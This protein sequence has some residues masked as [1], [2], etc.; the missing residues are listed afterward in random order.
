[1][2]WWQL[3]TSLTGSGDW[4]AVYWP[5]T[6]FWWLHQNWKW[7]YQSTSF[8]KNS[9]FGKFQALIMSLTWETKCFIRKKNCFEM[10]DLCMCRG[11]S[12]WL[13]N[14]PKGILFTD[15]KFHLN[16]SSGSGVWKKISLRGDAHPHLPLDDLSEFKV[17][18][19][20]FR[21]CLLN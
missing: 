18:L 5:E 17:G 14:I 10:R 13:E 3:T 6:E 1:M 20:R 4:C 9:Y 8:V 2:K 16:S 12:F 19:S 11:V 21:K 15:P 7:H